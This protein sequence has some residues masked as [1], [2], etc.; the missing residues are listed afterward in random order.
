MG[1]NQSV[2]APSAKRNIAVG[3]SGGPVERQNRDCLE[4]PIR[5]D[6]GNGIV[7][8]K[9]PDDFGIDNSGRDDVSGSE[10]FDSVSQ[11]FGQTLE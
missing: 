9:S 3:K 8:I 6:E 2:K 10:G 11:S 4:Q 5:F 1:C 7:R